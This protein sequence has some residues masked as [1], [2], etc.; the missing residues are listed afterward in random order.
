VRAEGAGHVSSASRVVESTLRRRGSRA[1]DQGLDGQLPPHSELPCESRSR[2]MA[3]LQSAVVIGGNGNDA[4]H[5]RPGQRLDD[6]VGGPRGDSPE[7]SLLPCRHDASR[8]DVVFDCGARLRERKPAPAALPATPHRPRGRCAAPFAKRRPDPPQL[9]P[10]AVADL[11]PRL[12]AGETALREKQVEHAPTLGVRP[13]CVRVSSVTNTRFARADRAAV[14]SRC[15]PRAADHDRR[16]PT[17]S[18]R[19]DTRIQTRALAATR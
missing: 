15:R 1:L 5:I 6:D 9:R 16:C 7:S 4:V 8:G 13:A 17:S 14:A 3:A 19:S 11:R 12:R 2:V 18:R 10:A